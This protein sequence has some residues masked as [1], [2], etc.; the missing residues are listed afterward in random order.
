V[1]P[2]EKATT[3]AAVHLMKYRRDAASP[4]AAPKDDRRF[5]NAAG[6]CIYK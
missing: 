4:F 3:I 5:A 2:V 6:Y 1:Q